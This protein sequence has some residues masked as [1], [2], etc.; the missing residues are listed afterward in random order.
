MLLDILEF[1]IAADMTGCSIRRV[2]VARMLQKKRS[3]N[4]LLKKI[5]KEKFDE[6]ES[7]TPA[8]SVNDFRASSTSLI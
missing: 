8:M 4:Q 6:D 5:R 1:R 2:C 7:K 3:A